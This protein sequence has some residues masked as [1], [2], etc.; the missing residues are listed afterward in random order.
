M[1]DVIGTD[2]NRLGSHPN[3]VLYNNCIESLND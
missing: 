2:P 1:N 3:R